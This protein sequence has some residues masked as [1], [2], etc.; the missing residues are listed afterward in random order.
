MGRQR[1]QPGGQVE[2][3]VESAGQETGICLCRFLL[4]GPGYSKYNLRHS[5]VL[6][7]DMIDFLR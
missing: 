4:S 5:S 3:G 1:A 2:T 6:I 7:R